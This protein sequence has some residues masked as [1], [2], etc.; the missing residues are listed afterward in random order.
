MGRFAT[1]KALL[2]A[3]PPHAVLISLP[4][5]MLEESVLRSTSGGTLS[6]AITRLESHMAIHSEKMAAGRM[7]PANA[8]DGGDGDL[9]KLKALKQIACMIKKHGS[10]CRERRREEGGRQG[11]P[12]CACSGFIWPNFRM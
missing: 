1:V 9:S 6:S 8:F 10:T 3:T 5:D 12:V 4:S 7:P 2:S 11:A